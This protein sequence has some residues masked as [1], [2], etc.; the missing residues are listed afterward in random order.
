[1]GYQPEGRGF[2]SM[3]LFVDIILPAALR[4]YNRNEYQQRVGLA[5]SP[6]SRGSFLEIWETQPPGTLRAFTRIGLRFTFLTEGS[7]GEFLV[8]ELLRLLKNS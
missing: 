8:N 2:D 4:L 6:P 5:T 7:K 1:M 3:E